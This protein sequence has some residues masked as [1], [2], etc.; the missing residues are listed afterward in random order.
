MSLFEDVLE[1]HYD[2]LRRVDGPRTVETIE[3]ALDSNIHD[4]DDL[5]VVLDWDTAHHIED[6]LMHIDLD[7]DLPES[8]V[9]TSCD[10]IGRAIGGETLF[11]GT[12][13]E[14]S[15]GVALHPIGVNYANEVISPG[16]VVAIDFT[17]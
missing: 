11:I 16:S 15:F 3:R 12:H 1:V 10:R 8:H 2:A 4:R 14:Q 17:D 5:T 13:S 7:L 6:G 9:E